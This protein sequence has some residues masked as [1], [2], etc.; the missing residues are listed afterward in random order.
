MYNLCHVILK[1]YERKDSIK[2]AEQVSSGI[3]EKSVTL[4]R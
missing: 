3:G 1:T 2:Q 4:F